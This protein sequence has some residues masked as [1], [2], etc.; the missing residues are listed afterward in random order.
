MRF[1]TISGS[2]AVA[3]TED[4]YLKEVC[5]RSPKSRNAGV[6]VA[7][8]AATDPAKEQETGGS[9]VTGSGLEER[10]PAPVAEDSS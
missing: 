8:E 3:A 2:L 4:R 10:L 6:H 9:A 7:R 1:L 5:H